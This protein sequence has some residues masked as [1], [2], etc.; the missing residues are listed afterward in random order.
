ML[1]HPTPSFITVIRVAS[2]LKE[3][4]QCKK[5]QSRSARIE[6]LPDP[7]SVIR[8]KYATVR[9]LDQLKNWDVSRPQ[10]AFDLQNSPAKVELG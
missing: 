3:A 4:A 6:I 2:G 1:H 8:V 10:R 9:G 5:I 7:S